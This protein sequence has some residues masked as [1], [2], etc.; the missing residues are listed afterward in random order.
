M[1]IL[2]IGEDVRD[3]IGGGH[4]HTRHRFEDHVEGSVEEYE[5]K[6]Q[7]FLGLKQYKE[8]SHV[9]PADELRH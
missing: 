7:D 5:A 8:S 3:H 1:V 2:Q 9:D 6:K 4:R